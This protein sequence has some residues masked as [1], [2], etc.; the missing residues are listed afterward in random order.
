M[1]EHAKIDRP[2]DVGLNAAI[3]EITSRLFPDGF[4][5][6]ETAPSTYQELKNHLDAGKRLVVYSGG[7]NGTIY[8]DPE[9]NYAF[10][11]WHDYTH[12]KGSFDFSVEGETA[13]CQEQCRQLVERYGDSAR[14]WCGILRA[15]VIGQRLFYQRHKKYVSDQRAFI[16]EYI[17]DPEITLMWSLW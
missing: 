10:R 17:R 13:V 8:A 9:V 2:L 11:A 7:S 14:R 1:N 12:W 15:E 3:L 4:D 16:E 6:C 5:V